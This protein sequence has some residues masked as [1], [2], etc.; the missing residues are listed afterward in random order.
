VFNIFINDIVEYINGDNSHAPSI[1]QITIPGLLFADDLAVSS[2]TSNGLQKEIDQIVRYCK[3]WNL[4]CNLR[5]SKIVVFKK[6]GKLKNT[7]RWNIAGQNIEI[8]DKF[9]YLGIT[10]ENTG[11]W[12]NQKASIKA[13]GNQ[14]LIAV[15]KSLATTPNMKVRILEYIYET[16]E[17]RIMYGVE[18]WGLDE[19]WKEV[20]RI[21]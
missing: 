16:C 18:L 13:E 3:E 10:V 11:G 17:S 19:A 2:F 1:G 14:A 6:G 21:H 8:I 9:K 5:K 20:D 4:K 12:M 15:N 7:E